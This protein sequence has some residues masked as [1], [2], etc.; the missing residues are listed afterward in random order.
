[1][2]FL[3]KIWR[4]FRTPSTGDSP[5][6]ANPI[7]QALVAAH[8]RLM[9]NDTAGAEKLSQQALKDAQAGPDRGLI[10]YALELLSFVW[11]TDET[12]QKGIEFFSEFL[13]F[14]PDDATALHSR[15]IHLWYSGRPDEAIADYNRS[16]HLKPDNIFALM[17]RGQILVELGRAQDAIVD[18]E[19]VLEMIN[20]FP[21]ARDKYWGPTQAYTRNGL[22]AASAAIG[23]F[24]RAFNEFGLSVDLQ[25]D[26]A[27]VYFNRAQAH[28]KNRDYPK[29]LLDYKKSLVSAEPK[30]PAYKRHLAEGRLKDLRVQGFGE[31]A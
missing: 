8:E 26:N 29:A 9:A 5:Q 10:E 28:D 13:R 30:L 19:R 1:M 12:N 6:A 24:S 11:M 4:F 17:G 20:A 16:L 22:G 3:A 7:F 21:N 2:K 18:L 31:E 25:P 14:H 23:D 15:G 27:W